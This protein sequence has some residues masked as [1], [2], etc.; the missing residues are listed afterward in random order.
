MLCVDCKLLSDYCM[1]SNERVV[2]SDNCTCLILYSLWNFS[3]FDYTC[4]RAVMPI[5]LSFHMVPTENHRYA[6]I[7]GILN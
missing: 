1:S 7:Q 3:I 5:F 4:C 6:C 2:H